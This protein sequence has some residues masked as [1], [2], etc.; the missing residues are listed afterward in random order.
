MDKVDF[1]IALESGEA[2]DEQII[3]NFQKMIDDGTVWQLQ[4]FYG[5]TAKAL[6]NAGYCHLPIQKGVNN[7]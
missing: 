6:I 5:R 2:T 7:A 4:G 3:E 1:I